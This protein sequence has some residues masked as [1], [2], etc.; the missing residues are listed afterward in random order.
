M[1]PSSRVSLQGRSVDSVI[2]RA[3]YLTLRKLERARVANDASTAQSTI[4]RSSE[5]LLPVFAVE[6]D[7]MWRCGMASAELE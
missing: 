7:E 3:M 4:A 2:K 5:Q 6:A 1:S